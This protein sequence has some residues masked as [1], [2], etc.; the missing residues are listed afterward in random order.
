MTVMT[1][2]IQERAEFADFLDTLTPEQWAAQTLCSGWTTRELVAHVISYD[3][4]GFAGSFRR[5]AR[6]RFSL[7]RT[8][9]LGV[10]E[11]SVN[12]PAELVGLLRTH[13]RPRGLTAA[14]GGMIA[15]VDGLIHQQDIRRPLGLPREI[16]AERLRTALRLALLAPP[17][18]AFSRVRGLRLVAAD[19]DFTRGSGPEVRGPGE[20][21][22]MAVSGRG[23]ALDELSGPGVPLLAQRV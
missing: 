2:A 5:L 23:H 13:R 1:L 8:N 3:D 12:S 7:A 18:G 11:Y 21:L 14:F 19:L 4:A 20:A 16:P 9:Q 10:T 6:G 15:L 22:L 17:L